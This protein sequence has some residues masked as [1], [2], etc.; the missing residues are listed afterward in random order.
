VKLILPGERDQV[1]DP[2][3]VGK[4]GVARLISRYRDLA[5]AVHL[6]AVEHQQSPV[7]QVELP[8]ALRIGDNAGDLELDLAGPRLEFL[9]GAG[10]LRYFDGDGPAD[11]IGVMPDAVGK[12]RGIREQV[13]QKRRRDDRFKL[14]VALAERSAG[15]ERE[16]PVF[17]IAGL[18]AERRV[19]VLLA[20]G[21]IDAA[22]R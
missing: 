5:F 20:V 6:V 15:N 10:K 1:R 7:R 9:A 16:Q 12:P 14:F 18:Q 22:S 8:A 21:A 17:R 3:A 4:P 2:R 19:N 13:G 11:E